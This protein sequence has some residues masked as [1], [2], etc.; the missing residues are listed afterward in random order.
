MYAHMLPRELAR[1]IINWHDKKVR[2]VINQIFSRR[3]LLVQKIELYKNH[4]RII[5]FIAMLSTKLILKYVD[6]SVIIKY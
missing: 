6:E 2:L 3:R 5:L 1:G 4:V